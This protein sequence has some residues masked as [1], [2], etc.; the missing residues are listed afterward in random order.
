[1]ADAKLHSTTPTPPG[2]DL[3]PIHECMHT[4]LEDVRDG[5]EQ[6]FLHDGHVVVALHQS[7]PH[8]VAALQTQR[9]QHVLV[10]HATAVQNLLRKKREIDTHV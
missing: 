7:G 9:L 2:M 8:V 4:Y 6:L 5:H 3:P 1:M 10:D